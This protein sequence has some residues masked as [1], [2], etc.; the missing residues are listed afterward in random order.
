M[1][2]TNQPPNKKISRIANFWCKAIYSFQINGRET[3]EIK[4]SITIFGIYSGSQRSDFLNAANITNQ[5][6]DQMEKVLKSNAS[7]EK[8]TMKLDRELKEMLGRLEKLSMIG[9]VNMKDRI[10][11]LFQQGQLFVQYL[12]QQDPHNDIRREALQRYR[13]RFQE[14]LDN[15]EYSTPL[16][17]SPEPT[18]EEKHAC[19]NWTACCEDECLI[20]YS[21]KMGANWFP[22][23]PR[24]QGKA[25]TRW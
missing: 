23:K 21:E 7:E 9:S 6:T 12:K 20:H 19:L 17:P 25:S 13:N 15:T 8:S 16:E 18:E 11:D 22:N 24:R 5:V 4:T 14:I 1:L 10:A 3:I 2:K